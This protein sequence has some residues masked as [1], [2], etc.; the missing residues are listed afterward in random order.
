MHN[1]LVMI[2]R[3]HDTSTH[4]NTRSELGHAPNNKDTLVMYYA[5][6]LQDNGRHHEAA[7]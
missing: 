1:T 5:L 4:V 7:A 2:T 6:R 3:S